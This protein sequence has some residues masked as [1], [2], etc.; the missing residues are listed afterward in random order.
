VRLI[1]YGTWLQGQKDTV[2]EF[3]D[4]LSGTKGG[5]MPWYGIMTDYHDANGN[6]PTATFN[7]GP[8]LFEP[9]TLGELKDS[10]APALLQKL[11]VAADPN[12]IFLIM[13][14]PDWPTSYRSNGFDY[15]TNGGGCGVHFAAPFQSNMGV[16]SHYALIGNPGPVVAGVPHC[17]PCVNPAAWTASPNQDVAV[18]AMLSTLAHELTETVSDPAQGGGWN[19][20]G[21]EGEAG[22]LCVGLFGPLSHDNNGAPFNIAFNGHNYLIQENFIPVDAVTGFCSLQAGF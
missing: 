12:T 5:P 19:N 6:H 18:D 9:G 11:N 8:D 22:D 2:R 4:N 10:T 16:M 15:C 17:A 7:V 14:G 21:P 3:L 13:I 1:F 20:P